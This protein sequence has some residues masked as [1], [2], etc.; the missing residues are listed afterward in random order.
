M[1][2]GLMLGINVIARVYGLTLGLRVYRY[3]SGFNVRVQ[4]VS[5]GFRVGR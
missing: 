5:L 4:C 3:G 2:Y 1:V